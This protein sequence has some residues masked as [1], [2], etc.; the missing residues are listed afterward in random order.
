MSSH[1]PR[2]IRTVMH[3]LR[4]RRLTVLRVESLTA[5]MRRVV[6]G[7]EALEAGFPF[8]AF[9]STDH[10]KL[11]LP[12]ELTGELRV[13]DVVD[14]R[15]ERPVTPPILRDYTV[16]RL[17]P[18]AGELWIDLV[19]HPHGPAGRWAERVAP[20]DEVGVLGPR[21]SHL[22]PDDY[23]RYLFV[24]DETA[25]PALARFLDDLDGRPATVIGLST[26]PDEFLDAARPGV[27]LRTLLLPVDGDRGAALTAALASEDLDDEDTFI[28]MAGEARSLI[29]ARRLLRERGIARE[30][31]EVDGYWKSGVAAHDHHAD[32]ED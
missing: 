32:L 24:A 10:V 7:G 4:S 12:D 16:R 2:R 14:D 23:A 3:P 20:G 22:Y 29:P 19:L 26:T 31:W 8:P 21:G 30:R 9:A 18:A 25:Q 28:W 5:R 17:D 27:T 11:V 6:L 13:P 15:I 1:T